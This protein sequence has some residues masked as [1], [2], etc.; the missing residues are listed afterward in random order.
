MYCSKCGKENKDDSIFCTGCGEKL[1]GTS[2]SIQKETPS[3]MDALSN[4]SGKAKLSENG[5]LNEIKK[6]VISP[7]VLITVIL[8]TLSIVTTISTAG[9]T[10]IDTLEYIDELMG[11]SGF[12]EFIEEEADAVIDIFEDFLVGIT[13]IFMLPSII[14]CAVLWIT[15][16]S[17]FNKKS[18]TLITGG[19]T[20]IKILNIIDIVLTVFGII[21]VFSVMIGIISDEMYAPTFLFFVLIAF[22]FVLLGVRIYYLKSINDMIHCFTYSVQSM[23]PALG[24]SNFVTVML[25]ISGGLQ[26]F[27]A[28]FSGTFASWCSALS[29][30][31]FAL[32]IIKYN[33]LTEYMRKEYYK[34]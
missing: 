2:T 4:L 8:M 24:M 1:D 21:S 9:D 20:A 13:I 33:A 25:F 16:Y 27:G 10:G 19:F 23:Y 30:I 34:P 29:T 17:A 15:I 3:I 14:T 5:V 22:V 18:D 6:F 31:G 26:V 11:S 28:F 32:I 7:L 12:S